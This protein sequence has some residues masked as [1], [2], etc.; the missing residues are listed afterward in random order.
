VFQNDKINYIEQDKNSIGGIHHLRKKKKNTE[1]KF[2]TKT[3]N[4]DQNKTSVYMFSDGIVDQ[5][6]ENNR[7]KFSRKRLKEILQRV[8]KL[9][10]DKQKEELQTATKNWQGNNRQTDDITIIGFKI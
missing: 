3:I 9:P 6:D 1:K 2:T 10:M 4:L 8:Y 5:F 7:K